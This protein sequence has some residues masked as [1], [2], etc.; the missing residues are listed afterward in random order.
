MIDRGY[1]TTAEFARLHGLSRSTVA[2][3]VDRGR[4]PARRVGSH[5]RIFREDLQAAGITATESL[6]RAVPRRKA[7]LQM[8]GA[9]RAAT[10]KGH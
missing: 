10:A 4:I 2:R 8:A 7:I 6:M 1:Y 3:L 5:R 9:I